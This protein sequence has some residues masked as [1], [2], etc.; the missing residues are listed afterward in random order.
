MKFDFLIKLLSHIKFH[1]TYQISS[2][3]ICGK[4]CS[5]LTVSSRLLT[6]YQ[7]VV[8]S[9]DIVNIKLPFDTLTFAI[10]QIVFF[11]PLGPSQY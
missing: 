11:I 1:K 2:A 3:Y 7:S 10:F 5:Y 9:S 4:V 6:R 8:C